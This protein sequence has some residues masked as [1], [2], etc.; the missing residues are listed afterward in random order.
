MACFVAFFQICVGD[1]ENG[2]ILC[3]HLVHRNV[4]NHFVHYTNHTCNS[5]V[6]SLTFVL[7]VGLETFGEVVSGE[8]LKVNHQLDRHESIFVVVREILVHDLHRLQIMY[9]CL[10][11]ILVLVAPRRGKIVQKPDCSGGSVLERE[12]GNVWFPSCCSR[13]R[14]P[15]LC[16]CEQPQPVGDSEHVF[17]Y[18]VYT[19]SILV[20]PLNLL[21]RVF[22]HTFFVVLDRVPSQLVGQVVSSPVVPEYPAIVPAVSD[23]LGSISQKTHRT[24]SA[25]PSDLDPFGIP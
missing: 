14:D 16:S 8:F 7:C 12:S 6:V 5:W 13:A 25:A 15:L 22:G 23:F 20:V 10:A 19:L 24:P 9:Q 17:V 18:P 2:P 11:D 1:A 4:P 3:V 21:L